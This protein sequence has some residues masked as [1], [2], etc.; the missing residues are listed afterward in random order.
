VGAESAE[1]GLRVFR[2]KEEEEE[3]EVVGVMGYAVSDG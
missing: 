1:L 2:G 3:E